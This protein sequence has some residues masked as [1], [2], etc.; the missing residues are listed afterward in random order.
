MK[1]RIWAWEEHQLYAQHV[2]V[3][4]LLAARLQQFVASQ[5]SINHVEQ[6]YP[7]MNIWSSLSSVDAIHPSPP[8]ST[9]LDMMDI[10]TANI[11]VPD[12]S[13]CTDSMIPLGNT[14]PSATH[15]L[16]QPVAVRSEFEAARTYT[17]Y[18]SLPIL[19][20]TDIQPSSI[21]LATD[22]TSVPK[23]YVNQL[24][25]LKAPGESKA[26]EPGVRCRRR[27]TPRYPSTGNWRLDQIE[28]MPY[29][30]AALA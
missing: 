9:Q 15:S 5:D 16:P 10:D 27:A 12:I 26:K 29:V 21:A 22:G 4:P 14:V 24:K 6:A 20:T 18:A 23:T 30:S 28:R 1:R 3:V 11:E 17:E 8:W 7:A 19:F 25:S 13:S 2:T